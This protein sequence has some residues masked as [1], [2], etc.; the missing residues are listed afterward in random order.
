MTGGGSDCDDD[1]DDGKC[2]Y[3]VGCWIDTDSVCLVPCSLIK[4]Q[5]RN[6][7]EFSLYFSFFGWL[8]CVI[9]IDSSFNE[10]F[11]Q[12]RNKRSKEAKTQVHT[13]M[14]IPL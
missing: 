11:W 2:F 7:H 1:D 3:C 4:D 6:R 8:Y 14:Y 9:C 13:F 5:N 10:E 12:R